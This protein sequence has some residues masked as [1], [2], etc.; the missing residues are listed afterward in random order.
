MREGYEIYE[1]YIAKYKKEID[2]GKE[3]V[4]ELMPLS[5]Y[6]R[7]LVKARIAK[8]LEELKDGENLWVKED[9]GKVQE[10]PL[11]VKIIEELDPDEVSFEPE[12]GTTLG[13][14]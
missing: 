3:I 4:C 10:K 5:T 9:S 2:E 12:K 6:C 11:S 8:S 13:L 14:Y 1:V 7:K